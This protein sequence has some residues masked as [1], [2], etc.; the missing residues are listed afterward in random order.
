MI[1]I[2]LA[3]GRGTRMYPFDNFTSKHLLPI[4][5]KP[6][7]YYSIS[8]LMLIGIKNILIVVSKNHSNDFQKLLLDGS[9]LGIKINFIEQDQPNGIVH[10]LKICQKY[11]KK[12]NF[13]LYLGDNIFYGHGVIN[14]FNKAK[15][16]IFKLSSVFTYKTTNP[17]AFGI[18][19]KDN[20]GNMVKIYEKPLK[21]ISDEAVT[22]IYFY[23][24]QVLK[25]IKK[26]KYSKRKELEISDLNNLLISKKK[27][28]YFYLGRGSTWYDCGSIDEMVTASNFFY[29]IEQK[30]GNKVYCPEEVSYNKNWISKKKIKKYVKKFKKL[31]L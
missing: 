19:K 17:K 29:E 12:N 26:I 27:L 7:I 3:G 31:K 13:V 1:G 18:L 11:I 21:Y 14:I 10:A 15:K 24:N 4:Y 2:I 25:L 8:T 22:G 23:N 9:Q 30:Q 16:I 5:D 28:K 6:L 20:M